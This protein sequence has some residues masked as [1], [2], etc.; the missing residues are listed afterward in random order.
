MG[1]AFQV[2]DVKKPLLAA[3]RSIEK[4]NHV[5]FGPSPE[6]NYIIDKMTGTR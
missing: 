5:T 6:D 1:L 4:G 3:K 2:A